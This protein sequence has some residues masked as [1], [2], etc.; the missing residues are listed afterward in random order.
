MPGTFALNP[1][2]QDQLAALSRNAEAAIP[3]IQKYGDELKQPGLQ[4]ANALKAPGGIVQA[5]KAVS[6]SPPRER[7]RNRSC[8]AKCISCWA[9]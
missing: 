7:E 9:N 3:L 5:I 8:A 2:A 6:D 4:A 1:Q